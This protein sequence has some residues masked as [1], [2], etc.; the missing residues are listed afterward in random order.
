MLL[1][2]RRK[3][4]HAGGILLIFLILWLGSWWAALITLGIGMTFLISGEYR[5]NKDKYKVIRSK[6]LDEIEE[7]AEKV[8]KEHERP[9]TLPFKGATEF[10]FGCFIAIAVF[11]PTIAMAGISVL[12]LAD[13]VSTLIGSC[14][15]KHKLPVNRKKSF[16]GSTA[17]FLTALLALVFFANPTRAVIAAFFAMLVEMLPH[18][19]DNLTIPFAVGLVLTLIS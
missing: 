12:S 19:D 4:V 17:F 2:I 11:P 13:A 9:N 5:K 7:A 3:I 10:F 6:K 14:Y 16:E 15:G 18:A 8:F 1:E